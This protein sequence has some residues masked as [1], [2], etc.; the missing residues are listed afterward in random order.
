MFWPRMVFNVVPAI[1]KH[2]NQESILCIECVYL[3]M[4]SPDGYC[5]GFLMLHLFTVWHR[6][7]VL[8]YKGQI[9]LVRVG[10]VEK[11]QTWSCLLLRTHCSS[12]SCVRP[13]RQVH[14]A[15]ECPFAYFAVHFIHLMLLA[16]VPHVLHALL[17]S[18]QCLRLGLN[19]YKKLFGVFFTPAVLLLVRKPVWTVPGNDTQ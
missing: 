8:E 10:N 7:R 19:V 5:C 4:V 3:S 15:S 1:L 14:W 13:G 2:L 17:I 9:W 16:W 18:G 6:K 11:R 12:L